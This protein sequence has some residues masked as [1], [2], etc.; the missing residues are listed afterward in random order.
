MLEAALAAP[1]CKKGQLSLR[2]L[3]LFSIGSSSKGSAPAPSSSSYEHLL[4][5]RHPRKGTLKP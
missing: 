4:A 2:Q 1:E 5:L 3:S